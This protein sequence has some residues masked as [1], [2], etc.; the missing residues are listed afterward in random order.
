MPCESSNTYDLPFYF[1]ELISGISCRDHNFGFEETNW[2]AYSKSKYSANYHILFRNSSQSYTHKGSLPQG[3]FAVTWSSSG[4]GG[5]DSI[6][7]YKAALSEPYEEYLRE[8]FNVSDWQGNIFSTQ[9]ANVSTNCSNGALGF[10][11]TINVIYSRV[12]VEDVV[13]YFD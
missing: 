13:I 1:D 4:F 2:W 9:A 10:F 12:A 3:T 8:K 6:Y 11:A 7:L 5:R